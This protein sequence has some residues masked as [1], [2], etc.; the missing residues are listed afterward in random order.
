MRLI[1]TLLF[2]LAWVILLALGCSKDDDEGR[3]TGSVN[4]PPDTPS[5]PYPAD[6]DSLISV[7][8]LLTW[9]CSDPD[10]DALTYAVYFNHL[11]NPAFMGNFSMNSYQ[12]WNLYNET[13]YYW[14][15]IA[16]DEQGS[17]TEGPVWS[18]NTIGDNPPDMPHSPYP[19]HNANNVPTN[20]DLSWQCSDPEGD[21]LTYTVYFDD[22][23][24]FFLPVSNHQTNNSYDL[25]D[26]FS[27]TTYYWKIKAHDSNGNDTT[28]PVWQFTTD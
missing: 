22:N 26:L 6:N 7:N 28:G 13:T 14:K 16:S 2:L 9:S 20:A 17:S 24:S 21:P 11:P 25:G 10:G 15:I 23:P 3:P 18:F 4:D 27:Q 1:T 8:V 12:Q 19:P 5:A